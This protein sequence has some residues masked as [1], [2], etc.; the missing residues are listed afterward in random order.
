M[1][2]KLYLLSSAV[3]AVSGY[4]PLIQA[5]TVT[6]E[7]VVVTAQ[8]REQSFQDVPISITAFSAEQIEQS[9]WKGARDF[10]QMT[11]NV[12]FSENDSQGTKNGDITI[13][14]ISDLTSGAGERIIQTRP[15]IGVFVD[16]FSV[17]SVSSGSANPPLGDV[18]R[19]EVLRG[20]QGTYFGRN[21]TGGAINIVS[22]KPNEEKEL[23][24]SAGLGNFGTY[25]LGA[26]ANTPLTDNLFVRLG[27]SYEESDG[28]VENLSPTGND[29]DYENTNIR[30]ALRWQPGDWTLDLTGQFIDEDE[31][32]LGKV[33]VDGGPGTFPVLFILGFDPNNL[34]ATCGKGES[35]NFADNDDRNCENA[36]TYTEVENNIITFKAEYEGDRFTFTSITGQIDSDFG[37]FEDLDNT[38]LDLFN[39]LNEYE[40]E[41]FSQEFRIA[42]AG[43]NMVDW[44]VGAFYYKDE[45]EVNNRIITGFDTVPG[46]TGFLTV[47]GD[48][49]NENQQFVDREGWAVFA[50]IA[51][52]INDQLTLNIGGRYSYDEDEQ[53]WENTYASFACGTREVVGGV[54][55]PLAPACELRPDQTLPLPVYESG[56]M[57]YV[58]G[59]R[60]PQR[61]FTQND[62]DD[63]DF[64]PRIALNWKFSEDHSLFATISQGYRPAGVRVAPDSDF[65][66]PDEQ[67][68]LATP[69]DTRSEFDK[70][71]VT[72]YEIGWK[73]YLNNRRTRV[74]VSLFRID[75][76]DMQVRVGRFIC[77]LSDG[78]PVD[79]SSSA[80]VGC[81]TGVT[82][83]NRVDNADE[84]RSQGAE[85]SVQTLIGDHIEL[86][87]AIGYMDAEFKDFDSSDGDLSGKDLLNAPELTGALSGQYNWRFNDGNG[88]LRLEANFRKGVWTRLGDLVASND[89]PMKT[90][91]FTVV[92]LRAGINWSN[93]RLAL[94]VNNLLEED[95]ILGI[96]TFAPSAVIL[97]HP[98]SYS[99][100]WSMSFK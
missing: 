37:Q 42:S 39:R 18:E 53:H 9:N 17:S 8:R 64:S 10:I 74:E 91:D 11:P 40:S 77:R 4:T 80:S 27:V 21:A 38:G 34:S 33:P 41:S 1:K 86:A 95:Y 35:I 7:E 60:L 48:Y 24:V 22:K 28:I 56:G 31:G 62:T 32:N 96:D 26:V 19:I 81:V 84:A 98:R 57:Q 68:G 30:L 36:D 58:T 43:E 76:E 67:L 12:S 93:Q 71:K 45:F 61:L 52:H 99:L 51:W 49:P 94:S 16:D 66:G 82:P 75:W 13:R 14:G 63:N 23:Q 69:V 87:G 70:E 2:P 5:E 78:T 46:F 73:G 44:T 92:N 88:Y 25:S 50:D 15:A 20:P 100:T 97:P 79:A 6:L 85:L 47:P 65:L 29:A 90:D 83:D 89:F 54:A 59:G 55:A 3:F 72:N